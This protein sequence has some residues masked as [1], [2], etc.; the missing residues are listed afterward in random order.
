ML[1]SAALSLLLCLALTVANPSP[2]PNLKTAANYAIVTYAGVTNAHV[3]PNTAS[4]ITGNV[5]DV[6]LMI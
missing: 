4:V 5:A 6:K 3:P 2:C 1:S